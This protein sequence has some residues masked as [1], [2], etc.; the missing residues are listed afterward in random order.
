MKRLYVFIALVPIIVAACGGGDDKCPDY[1]SI[2]LVTF[3]AENGPRDPPSKDD[4]ARICGISQYFDQASCILVDASK[5]PECPSASAD[6]QEMA[7]CRNASG[8]PLIKEC[9]AGGWREV[10]FRCAGDAGA[11]PPDP[12]PQV[13]VGCYTHNALACM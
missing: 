7:L 9:L 1:T 12:V 4:C 5:L 13:A 10:F 3:G 6:C 8:S 11:C 2:T